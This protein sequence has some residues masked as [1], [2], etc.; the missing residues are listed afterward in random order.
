ME[1]EAMKNTIVTT[2]TN[3]GLQVIGAIVLW[4]VGRS[5]RSEI[6]KETH[7]LLTMEKCG[8]ALI[9]KVTNDGNQDFLAKAGIG[10]RQGT[11]GL[12]HRRTRWL[13]QTNHRLSSF[14]SL[15]SPP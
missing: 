1:F 14:A 10:Q 13:Q 2:V 8:Y 7:V 12:I 4:I 9:E 6:K 5:V 15:T 11:A 3:V